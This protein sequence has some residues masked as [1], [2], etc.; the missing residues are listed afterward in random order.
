MMFNPDVAVERLK[1]GLAGMCA[2]ECAELILPPG[3]LR[4]SW[5]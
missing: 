3:S 4:G 5:S 1:E 2:P